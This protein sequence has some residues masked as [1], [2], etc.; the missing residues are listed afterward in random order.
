MSSV[1]KTK[2]LLKNSK[3]LLTV[4]MKG[5]PYVLPLDESIYVTSSKL[6]AIVNDMMTGEPFEAIPY[7][8]IKRVDIQPY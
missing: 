4:V 3:G 2:K 7:K 6:C 1:R 8:C 5:I